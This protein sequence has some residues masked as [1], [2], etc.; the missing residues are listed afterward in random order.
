MTTDTV[1]ALMAALKALDAREILVG[2]PAD[3]SPR[4][5]MAG[6]GS[7]ARTDTDGINNATLAYIQNFGSPANNIPA[8]EFMEPGILSA[9]DRITKALAATGRA[10]LDGDL[11]AID[12]GFNA[13][14]LIAQSAIRNKIT[15]GPFEAL[16]PATLAARRRSGFKGTRPLIVSGQ[17]RSSITYVIRER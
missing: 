1:S 17:L 16:K 9:Q 13:V 7:N 10:A 2:V 12:K 6:N 11:A 15:D 3:D 5:P 8:R 14:G 4:P